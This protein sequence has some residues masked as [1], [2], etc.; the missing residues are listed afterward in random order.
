MHADRHVRLMVL[1]PEQMLPALEA[2]LIDGFAAAEPWNSAAVLTGVGW[3]PVTS[4]AFQ[5]LHPETVLLLPESAARLRRGEVIALLRALNEACA[6]CDAPANRPALVSLLSARPCFQEVRDALPPALTGPF[7]AGNGVLLSP[8]DLLR[9][10][11]GDLHRPAAAK[12]TRLA[13]AFRKAGVNAPVERLPTVLQEEVFHEAFPT[14]GTP[15]SA[16]PG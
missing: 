11:G 2:R 3:C 4:A 5:P 16:E 7:D 15:E 12:W 13:A 9:F 10:H 14:P 8:R 6:W 1:P